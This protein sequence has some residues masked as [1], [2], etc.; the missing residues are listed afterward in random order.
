V[1]RANG[2]DVNP[3][4]D[5]HQW[6]GGKMATLGSLSSAVAAAEGLEST[7]VGLVARYLREAGLITMKGRG[8]SAAKMNAADAANLLIAVNA[9]SVAAS[10]ASV[11]SYY[12][13][14]E[15]QEVRSAKNPRPRRVLGTFGS[16]VEAVVE[17]YTRAELPSQFLG[18]GFAPE[19]EYQFAKGTLH[20]RISFFRPI[21][22]AS[23]RIVPQ[24]ADE[25]TGPGF[26]EYLENFA[27]PLRAF[28]FTEHRVN[29]LK[30]HRTGD[31]LEQTL[32][33]H[34]TLRAVGLCLSG[35][36]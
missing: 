1:Y 32:I 8:S 11:V 15:A 29:V 2:L 12:R 18:E 20:F 26:I 14:L 35:A 34:R 13:E 30:R 5:L 16:A 9:T 10:A 3:I 4:G 24:V 7:H 36:S 23:I 33:T 19:H 28:I 25:D 22:E 21:P 27:S 17:A 31:R 6:H